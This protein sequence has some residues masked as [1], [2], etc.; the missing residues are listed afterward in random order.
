MGYRPDL[1]NKIVITQPYP[2]WTQGDDFFQQAEPLI[3]ALE[4]LC[5]K[6]GRKFKYNEYDSTEVSSPFNELCVRLEEHGFTEA[7]LAEAVT[8]LKQIAQ[9]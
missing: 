4:S 7:E 9:M 8:L 3:N 5:S 6:Y 1:M 2:T